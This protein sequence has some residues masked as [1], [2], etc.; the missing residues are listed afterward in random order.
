[1]FDKDV[2]AFSPA[3]EVFLS[4]QLIQSNRELNDAIGNCRE[5]QSLSEGSEKSSSCGGFAAHHGKGCRFCGKLELFPKCSETILAQV[6]STELSVKFRAALA[7]LD[8]QLVLSGV[9][10]PSAARL[11]ICN[12]D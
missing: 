3:E 1:M 12:L 9:V 2:L 11:Q 7:V 10:L 5:T 8:S 6:Q 4:S